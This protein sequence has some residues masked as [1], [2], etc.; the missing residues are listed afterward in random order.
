M[1][2][3]LTGVQSSGIPHLGNVLGAILPAI[4][5]SKDK[6]NESFFYCRPALDNSS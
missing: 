2:R 4:K 6:A 3:I 1:A 5:I